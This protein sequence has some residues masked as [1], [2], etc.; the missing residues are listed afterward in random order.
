M[1]VQTLFWR[2]FRLA[3]GFIS[4]KRSQSQLYQQRW[5]I[6]AF[7]SSWIDQNNS[8]YRCKF[9]IRMDNTWGSLYECSTVSVY[10]HLKFARYLHRQWT[11]NQLLSSKLCFHALLSLKQLKRSV[12]HSGRIYLLWCLVRKLDKS[13]HNASGKYIN[14]EEDHYC[15]I[16]N[17]NIRF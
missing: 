16:N 9:W 14:K 7:R 8:N 12:N 2:I 15:S 3:Q 10:L 17:N 5:K 13:I 1:D 11:P 6:L 4:S